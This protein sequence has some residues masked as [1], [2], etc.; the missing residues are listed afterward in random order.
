MLLANNVAKMEPEIVKGTSL[1]NDIELFLQ[2]DE[3]Q[4]EIQKFKSE[5]L[6][7]QHKRYISM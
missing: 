7:E 4:N 1:S 5:L 3:N 6:V 2:V